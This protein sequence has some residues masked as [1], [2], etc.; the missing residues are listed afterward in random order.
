QILPA[1]LPLPP[2]ARQE[3]V[4]RKS[5]DRTED[6]ARLHPDRPYPRLSHPDFPCP[7]AASHPSGS[8]MP[9]REQI[10]SA[11]IPSR[12]AYMPRL[13]RRFGSARRWLTPSPYNVLDSW[14]PLQPYMH[15]VCASP[16]VPEP[17]G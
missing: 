5:E 6:P 15:G 1:Y 3:G 16:L 12:H 13:P 17:S 8:G 4:R 11:H 7:E 14:I 10:P 9:L 2:P